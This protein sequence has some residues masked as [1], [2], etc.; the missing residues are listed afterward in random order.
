MHSFPTPLFEHLSLILSRSAQP[1]D[2]GHKTRQL[3]LKDACVSCVLWLIFWSAIQLCTVGV[4]TE[5][6]VQES[7]KTVHYSFVMFAILSLQMYL[8]TR[9]TEFIFLLCAQFSRLH[10]GD[11]GITP[12]GKKALPK[13]REVLTWS[14]LQ[15]ILARWSCNTSQVIW[16]I[17]CLPPRQ[18]PNATHASIGKNKHFCVMVPT[19]ASSTS[20]KWRRVQLALE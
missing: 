1:P 19:A 18:F 14:L 15:C 12:S 4:Y 11:T 20:S 7:L 13:Q 9:C 16:G 10:Y 5:S 3:I 17:H 8:F 6:R 2:M